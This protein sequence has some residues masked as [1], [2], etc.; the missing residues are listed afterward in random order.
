MKTIIL[1]ILLNISIFATINDSDN[2]GMSQ[3]NSNVRSSN[4]DQHKLK[5]PLQNLFATTQWDLFLREFEMKLDFGVC[6]RENDFLSCAI[7][8]KAHMIEPIG[9]METTQKPLVFPF[10]KLDMGGNVL[11]GNS[12]MEAYEE[13]E[14]GRSVAGDSHMIYLPIM[15]I[16]FKKKL[17]FACFHK[18]DLMIPYMSEFDPTWKQD[19][20]SSK[21][22]PHMLTMFTP[23]GLLSSIF[24]CVAG[25]IVNSIL[26]YQDG[27]TIDLNAAAAEAGG[28]GTSDLAGNSN[29]M[30]SMAAASLEKMNEV[31]DTFYF[32][33]GCNGFSPVGG[34]VEGQDVLLDGTLV[35]HGLMATL[36]SASAISPIPFLSK[37]SNIF[38][39][40]SA[41]PKATDGG[42]VPDTMC[43]WK[44][45][46]LPIASQYMLQL[47]Y[48]TIGG[49]KELGVSGLEV[50]TAKNVPEA[51][52]SSVF[53]VWE[54]RDYYAF[55]YFCQDDKKGDQ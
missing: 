24:D 45:Y 29:H 2:T 37:Q 35:F 9:Y 13:A 47:A 36:H 52:N 49:A 5:A 14:G 50:S 43:E 28:G 3:V 4:Y 27:A 39:N 17:K 18:G 30:G 54:R 15:G 19:T 8:F 55:A 31:R 51:V 7:G 23:Q 1:L 34:Y 6:C 41:F 46:P 10:A 32:V 12:L 16:I 42:V 20:F 11:K 44:D 38:M 40:T 48:P 53:V 26:G 21:L 33:D 22:I 25:E